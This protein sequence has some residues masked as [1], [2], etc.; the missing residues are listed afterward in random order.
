MDNTD[1]S[2]EERYLEAQK[3]VKEIK[4]FYAHLVVCILVIP[5]LIFINLRFVPDFHWFWFPAF[6][7]GVSIIIHW[8]AVFGFGK[9]WEE[10]KV[11]ELMGEDNRPKY[12]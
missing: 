6:G 2:R 8:F 4:G 1:F 10:K 5:F 9:E 11:R 3:R 12:Q 7:L